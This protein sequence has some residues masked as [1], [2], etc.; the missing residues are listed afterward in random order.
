MYTLAAARTAIVRNEET[1]LPAV[2][3]PPALLICVVSRGCDAVSRMSRPSPVMSSTAPPP[4]LICC[5][6]LV[7]TFLTTSIITPRMNNQQ[8]HNE[9]SKYLSSYKVIFSLV[10]ALE[11]ET[12]AIRRFAKQGKSRGGSTGDGRLLIHLY[13]SAVT[14]NRKQVLTGSSESCE[15]KCR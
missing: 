5:H 15:H 7:T 4:G 11:L 8:R 12:K 3:R 14:G 1:C 10:P 9:Q 13:Y 2:M 6:C